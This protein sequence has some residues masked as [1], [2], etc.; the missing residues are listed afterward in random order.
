KSE[1]V[2]VKDLNGDGIISDSDK[3]VLGDP[4]PDLVWSMTNDFKIKNF[5]LSFMIQGSHGSQ[6]RNVGDQYFYTH[7]QGGT[8]DQGAELA[9]QNELIS[10]PTF[11]QDRV[12]T[13]DIVQGAGYLSLRNVNVGYSFP[14]GFV[15]KFGLESL[16]L[17][18]TGQNLIYYTMDEN[19]HGFNPEHSDSNTDAVLT[20]G[21]QRAGTPQY[22]TMTLGLN[23]DF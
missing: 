4:Y 22:R 13:N 15:S 7:W 23:I 21:G 10:H 17:Y 2:I 6:V 11:L 8:I 12:L 14:K 20:S 9:V 19:Y 1:Q 16:R 3:T 5:D 18:A